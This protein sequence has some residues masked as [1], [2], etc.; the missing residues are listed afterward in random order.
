[1]TPANLKKEVEN[2]GTAPYFFCKDTMKCFGDTMSNYGIRSAKIDTLHNKDVDVW[3]LYRKRPVKHGD[4][5]SAYWNKESFEE[6][7]EKVES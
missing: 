5:S 3:E 6:E 4:K 2:H 7:F 1:M